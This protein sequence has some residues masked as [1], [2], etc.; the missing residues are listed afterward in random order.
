[1]SKGHWCGTCRTHYTVAQE[2]L[3]GLHK[4]M[5]SEML[6]MINFAPSEKREITHKHL[7][8]AFEAQVRLKFKN[9]SEIF[10]DKE[11]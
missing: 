11:K 5:L 9:L 6:K 4:N 8:S 2:A 10:Q 3:F 7:T 1:M